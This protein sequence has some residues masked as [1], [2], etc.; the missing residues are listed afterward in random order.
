MNI[1]DRA[2]NMI[3]SPKTEWEFVSAEGT[4]AKEIIYRYVVPLAALA[5]IAA[6]IGYW[7]IGVRMLAVHLDGFRWGLYYG[8]MVFLQDILVV[9]IAA[10]VVD[11]LAPSFSSTKNINTSVQL[12]A[13]SYTPALIGGFLAIIPQ[14]SF[15]GS[16]FGLYGIYLWYIGLTPVKGTPPDKRAGYMILCIVVLILVYFII[17][18]ILGSILSALF[19]VS[20]LG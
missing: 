16:L 13:Y 17:G 20:M 3:I 15:L 6:F 2:K 14:I 10:F 12:V 5:G 1:V 19:G 8:V 18:W 11:A 9:I 7:L 4:P